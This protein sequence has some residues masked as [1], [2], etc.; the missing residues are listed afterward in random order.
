MEEAPEAVQVPVAFEIAERN[1]NV[2]GEHCL[3][4]IFSTLP[5][6]DRFATSLVCKNWYHVLKELGWIN[7]T[8]WKV[9]QHFIKR[10]NL[11]VNTVLQTLEKSIKYLTSCCIC[12]EHHPIINTR[13]HPRWIE[14]VFSMLSKGEKLR[15]VI[16]DFKVPSKILKNFFGKVINH[17]EEL[18]LLPSNKIDMVLFAPIFRKGSTLK[19][20]IW[21]INPKDFNARHLIIFMEALPRTITHMHIQM[22]E[23]YFIESILTNMDRFDNLEELHIIGNEVKLIRPIYFARPTKLSVLH[24]SKINPKTNLSFLSGVCGLKKLILFG[25]RITT[26]IAQKFVSNN[27]EIEEIDI[28]NIVGF[29]D[30]I[31]DKFLNLRFLKKLSISHQTEIRGTNLRRCDNLKKLCL[32]SCPSLTEESMTNLL[33]HARCMRLLILI[34][35]DM[36]TENMIEICRGV[37]RE[38]R[39]CL[40]ILRNNGQ[41][42]VYFFPEL[43]PGQYVDLKDE[44]DEIHEMLQRIENGEED[45]PFLRRMY[46]DIIREQTRE[47]NQVQNHREEEQ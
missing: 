35:N 2:I 43:Q 41:I 28:G 30:D 22:P 42:Q 17:L 25:G 39:F 36:I 44:Y 7:V 12:F 23:A 32:Y 31:L 5:I 37:Q 21:E 33:G 6:Q 40:Y 26:E 11:T 34:E 18:V 14:K 4:R 20:I 10:P 47:Q 16:W 46:E 13:D 3:I 38:E 15:S 1:F 29:N 19:T 45:L 27:R 9:C 8:G 24:I